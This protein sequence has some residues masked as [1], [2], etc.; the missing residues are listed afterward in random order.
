MARFQWN[1]VDCM[2]KSGRVESPVVGRID[3][4]MMISS[5]R[6]NRTGVATEECG[7][8]QLQTNQDARK[9]IAI[10][11]VIVFGVVAVLRQPIAQTM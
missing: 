4:E 3:G 5:A 1:G 11:V 7:A 8:W 2:G 9:Q 10:V 6:E